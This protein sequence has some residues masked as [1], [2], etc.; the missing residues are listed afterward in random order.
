MALTIDR[1]AFIDILTEGTGLPAAAMQPPPGGHLGHAAGRCWKSCPATVPTSRQ[2][3]AEAR[4]IMEKLGY[5]PDKRLKITVVDPRH[6]ALS[7]PGGDPDRSAEGDLH[8]RRTRADRHDA[9]VPDDDAQGLHGRAQP[10]RHLGRR[11][12][13][14]AL[15]ELRLRR[16]R[17][18]QRLLQ[19]GGRQA[20]RPAIDGAEPGEAQAAGLGDRA[21]PDR[22]RRQAAG[23][24]QQRRRP[25]GSP[26]SRT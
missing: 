17:Q 19:P 7:R 25:A 15:R 21:P 20:D 5:G 6:P 8:R 10:D 22:G 16:G 11:P 14:A 23:L 4:E 18:L 1:Q 13:R 2:N 9:V 24:F 12:R 3:R 26:R